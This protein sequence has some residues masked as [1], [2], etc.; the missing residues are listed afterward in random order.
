MTPWT[1][2]ILN[3]SIT[4]SKAIVTICATSSDDSS[5]DHDGLPGLNQVG[6][7]SL[8]TV[9]TSMYISGMPA[10]KILP[11]LPWG[12]LAVNVFRHACQGI[13]ADR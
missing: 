2:L 12:V 10:L 13:F 3:K 9:L 1:L 5:A 11:R 8:Q 6:D 7:Q 4:Y